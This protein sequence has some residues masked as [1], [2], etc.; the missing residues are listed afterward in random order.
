MKVTFPHMGTAYIPLKTLFEELGHEV[1]VPP[2]ISKQT[3]ML[4]VKYAPEFACL[5]LK[6]NMGNFIEACRCGADT[7]V[8]AGGGGPCRFGYYAQVQREILKDLGFDIRFIV[9]E[10]PEGGLKEAWTNFRALTNNQPLSTVMRACRVGFAKCRALDTLEKLTLQLR[11]RELNRGDVTRA[12]EQGLNLIAEAKTVSGVNGALA[13][14]CQ[15]MKNLPLDWE[16][17]PYRVA[18]VGE[19]YMLLEPF[20]SLNIQR[21]LGELGAA[22]DKTLYLSE[23]VREHIVLGGL[24]LPHGRK[25]A[26]AAKPYLNHFVGGHGLETIGH[27]VLA[28]HQGFDGVVQLLPFTC[29][30][31]IVAESILPVINHERGIPVLTLVLDEQSGEAGVQT[32]LEAFIDLVAQNSVNWR[33]QKVWMPT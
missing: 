18:L 15:G 30:P 33:E 31:E 12:W 20:A 3:I 19:I 23:W 10:M 8:M 5:P 28:A 16:R 24:H 4:G 9:V 22:V 11:P 29:M 2:P 1:I 6:L 7:V 25:V 32:R 21:Q 13:Y 26:K 27:T 17:R 14:A